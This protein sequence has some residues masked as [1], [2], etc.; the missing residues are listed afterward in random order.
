MT[1]RCYVY[2]L[3]DPRESDRKASLRYVGITTQKPEMR[4]KRHL[5][6]ARVLRVACHRAWWIRS[7]DALGL[8]PV[9]QVLCVT[10]VEHAKRTEI[11]LI[12]KLRAAGYGLTNLTDGGDG[13][14]GRPIP[15]HVKAKMSADRTGKPSPLKGVPTGRPGWNR[16]QPCPEWLK[17]RVSEANTGR[18]SPQKGKPSPFRGVPRSAEVRAKISAATKGVKKTF[19]ADAK[20]AALSL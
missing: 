7:L 2:A 8:L 13:T 9:V 11:A 12:A 17:K 5:W 19:R 1:R 14:V 3:R 6:E 16:G 20:Q 4:L 15:E 10:S 18:V